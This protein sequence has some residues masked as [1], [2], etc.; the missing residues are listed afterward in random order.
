MTTFK[1][2]LAQFWIVAWDYATGDRIETTETKIQ[3]SK[4]NV[5]PNCGQFTDEKIIMSEDYTRIMSLI[6][7]TRKAT[8]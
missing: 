4:K 2:N 7:K 3:F 6:A 8:E 1:N 5:C